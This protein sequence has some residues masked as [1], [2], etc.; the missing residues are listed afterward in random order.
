MTNCMHTIIF[1]VVER[2]SGEV[3]RGN[4]ARDSNGKKVVELE[5]V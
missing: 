4:E 2:R 1:D 3:M 5:E